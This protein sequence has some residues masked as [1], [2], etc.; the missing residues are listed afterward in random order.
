[1][2]GKWRY[3][4]DFLLDFRHFV[5]E[6]VS[7][8]WEAWMEHLYDVSE[9]DDEEKDDGDRGEEESGGNDSDSREYVEARDD[10]AAG[11][12]AAKIST[13]P[14]RPASPPIRGKQPQPP[15]Y[16]DALLTPSASWMDT[17]SHARA[18][19]VYRYLIQ[20]EEGGEA[21]DEWEF[22]DREDGLV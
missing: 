17:S 16:G 8:D 20:E 18:G 14:P 5:T 12:K 3:D 10:A 21:E 1:M 9:E 22:V 6:E 11:K 19:G 15:S 7:E 13:T 4:E 2:K